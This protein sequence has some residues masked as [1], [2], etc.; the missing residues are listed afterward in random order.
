MHRLF[1]WGVLVLSIVFINHDQAISG[2]GSFVTVEELKR[3]L[4]TK[5]VDHIVE[6]LN[7][8]KSMRYQGEILPLVED[9]WVG[10]VNEYPDLPPDTINSPIVKVEFAN[11]LLQAERNGRIKTDRER[12]YRFV[13]PLI[14]SSDVQVAQTA[15]FTLSLFDQERA[16]KAILA[17][18]AEENRATFRV[19]VIGL[20]W[21]CDPSARR[22]LEELIPRVKSGENKSIIRDAL[23]ESESKK[24]KTGICDRQ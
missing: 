18:A 13:E 6:T 1:I 15:I 9:L 10:K 2:G 19:A 5:N 16:T 7:N 3:V 11:I 23:Q 21:M 12:I 17:V 24:H 4:K 20:S 8:V 14:N 22:A